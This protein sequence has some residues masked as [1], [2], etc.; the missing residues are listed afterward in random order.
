MIPVRDNIGERGA[1]PAA[2][3]ICALV[4]LAGIFL[5]DGNIWVALMA[6]FGAWIFAPTPVRELGA[7]PVLLIAT[8]GGLIAWWVAQD[9]NSAVG[10]WAPLASTGAIALVHLLKHPRAQVIG[11]VPIPY[12][13]S[14]TEAPSVVVII[15]WAAAAVI[16]ALVVQTR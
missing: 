16:L 7:I 10:I 11:L 12:R 8:A 5:P 4:L 9:A 14:L 1:S 2:L 15:I 3:V 13:T 6:G